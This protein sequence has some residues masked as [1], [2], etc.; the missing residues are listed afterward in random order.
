MNYIVNTVE[1]FFVKLDKMQRDLDAFSQTLDNRSDRIPLLLK[2]F[3]DNVF[4]PAQSIKTEG[5]DAVA[6]AAKKSLE[7]LRAVVS[8]WSDKIEADRKGKEFIK[9]NE[10]FL[11][12]RRMI[13]AS[14]SRC[15]IRR[16]TRKN[17]GR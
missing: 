6:Q 4:K 1:D 5:R 15:D 13:S 2:N 10:K 8:T 7:N 12:V 16:S 14:G 11:V 17:F 3:E 9:K